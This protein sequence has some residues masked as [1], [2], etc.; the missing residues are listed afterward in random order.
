MKQVTATNVLEEDNIALRSWERLRE[1]AFPTAPARLEVEKTSVAP[2]KDDPGHHDGSDDLIVGQ[3]YADITLESDE[4]RSPLGASRHEA[5]ATAKAAA[6]RLPANAKS[7][8]STD[9]FVGMAALRAWMLELAHSNSGE[10]YLIPD[11]YE[12]NFQSLVA[13]CYASLTAAGASSAAIRREAFLEW[14]RDLLEP[15]VLR[16]VA[17]VDRVTPQM[18]ESMGMKACAKRAL[19]T[20]ATGLSFSLDDLHFAIQRNDV[21]QIIRIVARSGLVGL[22]PDSRGAARVFIVAMKPLFVINCAYDLW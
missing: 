7:T 16:T 15:H 14:F 12:N 3:G 1:L 21:L 11:R 9:A 8:A 19:S 20:G 18:L 13:L 22:A 2:R 10:P 6:S 17:A 4:D 5:V